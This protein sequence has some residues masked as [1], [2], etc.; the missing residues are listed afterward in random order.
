VLLVLIS[1][2]SDSCYA[3]ATGTAGEWLRTRSPMFGKRLAWVSGGI[4]ITL[5]VGAAIS[6]SRATVVSAD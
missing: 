4:Y 2:V 1:M 6:G 3:L 5:G